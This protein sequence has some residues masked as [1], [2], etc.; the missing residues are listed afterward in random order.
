MA[1]ARCI[2]LPGCAIAFAAGVGLGD[3]ACSTETLLARA[4]VLSAAS[5]I[6]AVALRSAHT[7][8]GAGALLLL[9]VLL[10]GA[11]RAG[12][13]AEPPMPSPPPVTGVQ[14]HTALVQDGP[15]P[16]AHDGGSYVELELLD[17]HPE[18]AGRNVR[19]FSAEPLEHV[20]VGAH[21][22]FRAR[23]RERRPFGNPGEFV[24]PR[25]E[26]GW[27]AFVA[28]AEAVA[29]LAREPLAREPTAQ[30]RPTLAAR[31]NRLARAIIGA[32]DERTGGTIAAL[33]LGARQLVPHNVRED[34]ARA[35]TAH[36]LAIS[37]LHLGIVGLW[38]YALFG[39]LLKRSEW[40]LLRLRLDRLRAAATIAALTAFTLL[41]GAAIPTTRA[42]AM[43]ALF[44][45]GRIFGR[46]MSGRDALSVAVLLL[47]SAAPDLLRSVSFQLSVSAVSALLYTAPAGRALAREMFA[48]HRTGP[49]LGA[50]GKWLFA[51]LWASVAAGIGTAPVLV[52]HFGRVPLL[53]FAANFVAVPFLA[54]MVLPTAL[55]GAFATAILPCFAHPAALALPA[56]VMQSWLEA[57]SLMARGAPEVFFPPHPVII[58]AFVVATMTAL[59]LLSL[60]AGPV[61][62]EGHRAAAR[63]R[64]ALTPRPNAA[65]RSKRPPRRLAT[66]L[67]LV[68]AV[69]VAVTY[70][71]PHPPPLPATLAVRA[72][73]E[74]G[75]KLTAVVLNVSHGV[76]VVL[77]LPDGRRALVDGGGGRTGRSRVGRARVLPALRALGIGHLD[78]MVLSHAHADHLEGLMEVATMM[79]V[80]ELWTSAAT[81]GGVRLRMLEQIV[82]AGGGRIRRLAA[83]DIL[84]SPEVLPSH[85]LWP[86]ANLP[87]ADGQRD[88]ENDRSL[89][90]NIG[91]E[92]AR[93][94]LPGDAELFAEEA[95]LASLGEDQSR[96]RAEVVVAP[97]HGSATSSSRAWLAAVRPRAVIY[98]RGEGP[99]PRLPALSV[100]ARY[101]EKGA[102]AFDT[103][104]DGAIGIRLVPS[105]VFVWSLGRPPH[106]GRG[107]HLTR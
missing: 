60:L 69:A 4:L 14:T 65:R 5:A 81:R 88:D 74:D 22:A 23:L 73:T 31:R 27:T 78:I 57:I 92:G 66:M 38:F 18:R 75:P 59:R 26:R 96:L 93:L 43:A 72:S 15:W 11:L 37:G 89:V 71:P 85:V 63:A 12:A 44:L 21:V 2:F 20:A 87:P 1:R 36:A 42:L 107:L 7:T 49:L 8:R 101:R 84:F 39:V 100:A 104:L 105:G 3:G 70:S 50:A 33:S 90:L 51:G 98:S 67:T 106:A 17:D 82:T 94:L 9:V 32:T 40:L 53:T 52:T 46:E 45:L 62:S 86:P 83:G 35:G 91:R 56:F 97:H 16:R 102:R 64:R 10:A 80:D 99:R 25:A 58:A 55:L 19:L 47:L 61:S 13:T 30:P 29:P 68:S 41:A 103:A 48:P 79:S 77:M 24:P 54:L 6:L 28:T 34:F 76:A 95:L